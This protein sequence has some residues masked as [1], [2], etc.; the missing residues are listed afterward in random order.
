MDKKISQLNNLFYLLFTL[1][2]VQ[3][4][5]ILYFSP[6]DIAF[7][8]LDYYQIKIAIIILN[9]IVLISLKMLKKYFETLVKSCKVDNEKYFYFRAKILFSVLIIV[10]MEI[11]NGMAYLITDENLIV[12]VYFL[13]AIFTLIFI[14]TEKSFKKFTA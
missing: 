1:I 3:G 13:I 9:T 7:S 8:I 14:P 6:I 12:A 2:I 5:S 10:F 11:I 4:I